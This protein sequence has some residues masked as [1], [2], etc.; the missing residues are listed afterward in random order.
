MNIFD[1]IFKSLPFCADIDRVVEGGYTPACVTGLSSVHKAQAAMYLGERSKCIILCDDEASAT[2][3]ANDINELSQQEMAVIFP[4]KDLNFT[5]LEGASREYEHRR[6]GALSAIVS[7]KASVLIC[8]VEAAMQ[9]TI[10]AS[11]L[12]EHTFTLSQGD[13]ISVDELSQRLIDCG[14]SRCDQ[15][16]GAAQF[17][18]R[19]S[20]VDIFSVSD[21]QP[22]HFAIS[23][24]RPSAALSRLTASL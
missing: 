9:L 2:R 7:G 10:P 13:E 19:G 6:I 14:Y 22:F 1:K 16:E 11:K 24:H 4:A 20:I 3:M 17:S 5:Y 23:I 8:S 21:K 12:S 18:V 15:V